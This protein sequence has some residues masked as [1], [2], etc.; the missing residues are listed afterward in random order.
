[1]T[2]EGRVVVVTGG[3]RGIGR[4]LV[5]GFMGAGSKVVVIDLSWD[6][7][8]DFAHDIEGHGGLTLSADQRD[9]ASIEAAFTDTMRKFGTVDVLVN[10]AGLRQRNMVPWMYVKTLELE[11]EKWQ[12]MVDVNV[13]G[14]LRVTRQFVAPM[15]QQRS[16]SIVNVGSITGDMA[17]PGMQPYAMSKAALKSW[18][19]SLA[20]ELA[21][22][23]IAVNVFSPGMSWTTGSGEAQEEA[24]RVLG[25]TTFPPIYRPESC[26]PLVLLLAGQDAR[27]TGQWI[28]DVIEWNLLHGLGGHDTW[29]HES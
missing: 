26:V 21:E 7:E 2:L 15:I 6:G 3:A 12:L 4:A 24:T 1:M 28:P 18:T 9:E 17:V 13:L 25:M 27:F 19:L 20:K 23:N 16:G 8:A 29:V 22:H 11:I 14:P 5:E 10:N